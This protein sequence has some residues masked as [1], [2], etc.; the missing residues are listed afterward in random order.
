MSERPD[1]MFSRHHARRV[2]WLALAFLLF[3]VLYPSP[4]FP[5]SP[6]ERNAS[7]FAESDY[8]EI[9]GF[10]QAHTRP[11]ALVASDAY[12]LVSWYGDRATLWFP[13]DVKTLEEIERSYVNVDAVFLTPTFVSAAANTDPIWLNL[14]NKPE[15]FGRFQ[16]V[17]EFT[18]AHGL[19]V[20]LF[21]KSEG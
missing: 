4:A 15:P 10:L 21:L 7:G 18:S 2:G 20:V 19:R 16:V 8:R 12:W 3:L 11:D 14:Y 17:R 6:A 13:V 1:L 5:W 9:G